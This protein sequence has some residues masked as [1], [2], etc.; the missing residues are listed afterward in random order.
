MDWVQI[1]QALGTILIGWFTYNQYAKNKITDYK[2]EK[3][4]KEDMEKNK[5]MAEN[6]MIVFGELWSLLYKLDADRVYIAQPHPLGHE[7]LISVNFEV[8]HDG[9]GSVKDKI[10]NVKIDAIGCFSADLAKN[11]FIHIDDV[12]SQVKE[13]YV[14][15]IISTCGSENIFIKRL[16]NN[17][18]KWIGNIFCEYLDKRDIDEKEAEKIMKNT[19]IKIQ[20]ILPEFNNL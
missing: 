14:Q 13:K 1:I 8:R 2:I 19:A 9:I 4:K 10:K 6:A 5:R 11:S 16:S 20:Y 7:E 3:L 17:D 15:S 18:Y 12:N